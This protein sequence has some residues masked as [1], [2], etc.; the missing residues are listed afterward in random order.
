MIFATAGT[1]LPFDRFVEALDRIAPDLA[2]PLVVQALPGSYVPRNFDLRPMLSRDEFDR[3]VSGCSL[4]VAHAGIGSV[5]EALRLSKPVVV[6]PRKAALGEHRNDH[7]MAT[8]RRFGKLGY[9]Y[10]AYD[11]DDL[12]SLLCGEPLYPL[13]A[14]GASASDELCR[15]VRSFIKNS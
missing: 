15:F 13:Q 4:M 5:V 11:A 8:A 1:Q 10:V 7:Q 14:I 6:F 12:R 2:E 9:A 3:C